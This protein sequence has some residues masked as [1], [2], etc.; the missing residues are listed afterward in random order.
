M[1]TPATLTCTVTEQYDTDGIIKWEIS[2]DSWISANSD[3][4]Y[5]IDYKLPATNVE[6]HGM[7]AVKSETTLTISNF[8]GVDA[9]W[10]NYGC[11]LDYSSYPDWNE[12]SDTISISVL[13]KYSRLYI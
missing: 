3:P 7:E 11:K 6:V 9:S 4:K 2:D 12:Y 10:E 8:T 13:G 5:T 1:G